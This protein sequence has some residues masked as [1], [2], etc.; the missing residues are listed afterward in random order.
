MIIEYANPTENASTLR[1][2]VEHDM[3]VMTPTTGELVKEAKSV[4]QLGKYSLVKTLLAT[5]KTRV[6]GASWSILF[7]PI[8][9]R[10]KGS[11][12]CFGCDQF[13]VMQLQDKTAKE[14]GKCKTVKKLQAFFGRPNLSV[15]G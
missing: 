12:N 13:H 15:N 3:I 4:A 11:G 14:C 2:A 1:V 9:W 5:E 8:R 6:C 10:S 7:K